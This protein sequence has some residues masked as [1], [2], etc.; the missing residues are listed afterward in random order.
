MINRF[1]FYLF[2]NRFNEYLPDL[3][4]CILKLHNFSSMLTIQA[5]AKKLTKFDMYLQAKVKQWKSTEPKCRI[6]NKQQLSIQ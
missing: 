5:D 2:F 3:Y 4:Y 1:T 6:E